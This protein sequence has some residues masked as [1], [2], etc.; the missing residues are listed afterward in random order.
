[1]TITHLPIYSQSG[2][3]NMRFE[4]S[5]YL[6]QDCFVPLSLALFSLFFLIC[7]ILGFIKNKTF[8]IIEIGKCV[9]LL[10]IGCYLFGINAIHLS[11]GGLYLL[12]EHESSQIQ[13]SGIVEETIEIDS[14]TGA[15]YRVENQYSNHGNGEALVVNGEKYYLITYGDTK[16][17]DFVHLSV[18]PKSHF[19]LEL[20]KCSNN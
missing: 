19:V 4:Y 13:I 17:G 16:V 12:F 6:R 20:S 8:D 14:V 1:M 7:V 10:S 5:I 2:E 9:L 11:R 15:K 18:L 3:P